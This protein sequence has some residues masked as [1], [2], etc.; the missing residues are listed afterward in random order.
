MRA[1]RQKIGKSNARPS[2]TKAR[3]RPAPKVINALTGAART[4]ARDK[5]KRARY[6]A[7]KNL[8][9]LQGTGTVIAVDHSASGTKTGVLVGVTGPKG[10]LSSDPAVSVA[11][12]IRRALT[13]RPRNDCI[14]YD[15]AGQPIAIIDSV[16]RQ[17]RPW[18][19]P[20]GAA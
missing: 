9:A 2:E 10:G 8:E 19:P 20:E 1:L 18:T 17:R 7:A 16:T 4:A 12:Q 14:V 6:R 15:A 11:W 5:I 13:V 3:P